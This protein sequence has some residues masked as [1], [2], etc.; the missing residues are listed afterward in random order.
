[1]DDICKAVNLRGINAGQ[2]CTSRVSRYGYCASHL[3]SK[4]IQKSL[5]DQGIDVNAPIAKS[6]P[7]R[8]MAHDMV[9]ESLRTGKP[10]TDADIINAVNKTPQND[11]VNAMN[12]I[13]RPNIPKPVVAPPPKPPVVKQPKL[14][15]VQEEER[16]ESIFADGFRK[17]ALAQLNNEAE[18]QEIDIAKI[19]NIDDEEIDDTDQ[20]PDDETESQSKRAQS[21]RRRITE[22]YEE[23]REEEEEEEEEE[24]PI[25]PRKLAPEEIHKRKK[26]T[27][28]TTKTLLTMGVLACTKISESLADPKLKGF[29][30]ELLSL[31][32]FN[33]ALDELALDCE[34]ELGLSEMG[35]GMR[36][37]L[38]GAGVAGK[39][40]LVNTYGGTKDQQNEAVKTPVAKQDVVYTA[41]DYKPAFVE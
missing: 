28:I 7:M 4:H 24:A 40:M 29:T 10:I 36:L 11:V 38:I 2:Q 12:N 32:E 39:V 9:S 20:D 5:L 1:M 8:L 3:R 16:K 14:T 27:T 17:K 34:E 13:S 22:K 21:V 25:P 37:F 30:E 6:I 23:A 41:G 15:K 31:E 26:G 33:D 35:P 18:V 19:Y